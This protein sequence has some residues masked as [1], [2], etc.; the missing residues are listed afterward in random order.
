[1]IS[2]LFFSPRMSGYMVVSK[3]SNSEVRCT[4]LLSIRI[5]AKTVE[6]VNVVVLIVVN[7]Q[8]SCN[9]SVILLSPYIKVNESKQKFIVTQHNPIQQYLHAPA[10][11][12]IIEYLVTI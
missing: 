7:V 1:M 11:Q 2:V 6:M 3:A 4:S 9:L 12:S 10:P 5:K 8:S